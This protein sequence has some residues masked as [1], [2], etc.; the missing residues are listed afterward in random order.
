MTSA[1]LVPPVKSNLYLQFLCCNFFLIYV[2]DF[3]KGKDYRQ[4]YKQ[5]LLWNA[6]FLFSKKNGIWQQWLH[7]LLL[8]LT[9]REKRT[10]RRLLR[11]RS[12]FNGFFSIV[13][14]KLKNCITFWC[15]DLTKHFVGNIPAEQIVLRYKTMCLLKSVFV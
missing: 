3:K 14:N 13:Y 15:H 5:S 2:T 11:L 8:S 10:K 12:D 7:N 1:F 6:T 9:T 4:V